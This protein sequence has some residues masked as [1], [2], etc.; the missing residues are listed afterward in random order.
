MLS[1]ILLYCCR[2]A[3]LNIHRE[4]LNTTMPPTPTIIAMGS[5]CTAADVLGFLGGILQRTLAAARH[6][7]DSLAQ[8]RRRRNRKVLTWKTALTQ[9]STTPLSPGC[10]VHWFLHCT[11]TWPCRRGS[12]R[13]SGE[14]QHQTRPRFLCQG[15]CGD[16]TTWLGG[17]V[18]DEALPRSESADRI[19]GT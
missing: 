11:L 8:R 16:S 19:A 7:I 4:Q 1:L 18:R 14:Q 13:Y 3:Q 6:H 10:S 17:D 12:S 9:T 5:S 2:L 15:D